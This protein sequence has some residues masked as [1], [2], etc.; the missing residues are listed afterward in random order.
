MEKVIENIVNEYTK[1]SDAQP[2]LFQTFS[3]YWWTVI[4]YPD[5][6]AGWDM[7]KFYCYQSIRE[8]DYASGSIMFMRKLKKSKKNSLI[9][10]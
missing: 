3:N 1:A 6:V 4:Y 10:W 9:A 5:H 8:D 7:H 2:K